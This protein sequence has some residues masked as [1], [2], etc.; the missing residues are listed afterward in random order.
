MAVDPRAEAL[1]ALARFVVARTSMGDT[2]LRVAE[3]TTAALPRA[4]IAGIAMLGEDGRPTTRI[5][6]DEESP[7]IDE[8]QYRS[9]NGPCLDA[10]REARTVRIDE[11]LAAREDYPDFANLALDH[12]V[13]STLSL[14]LIAGEEAIGAL[15]LYSREAFGF[16]PEDEVLGEELAT[17]AA[18]VLANASAYWAAFALGEGLKEALR[19]RAVIEQA[20][21]M[22]MASSPHIDADV[23]FDI[24]R[25]ASQRENTKLREVARRIVN[26]EALSQGPA[27]H[28]EQGAEER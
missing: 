10:W 21:G 4:A 23:A 17:T 18:V 7:E 9:G 22:L 2:L 12:G 11:M 3:I 26:R 13:L 14:P 5:Y 20:K 16:S 8:G 15:N 25:R 28:D 19:S 24:L 1:S 6:T 27:S